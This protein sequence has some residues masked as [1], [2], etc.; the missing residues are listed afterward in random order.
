[1]PVSPCGTRIVGLLQPYV[2]KLKS[3]FEKISIFEKK[4][5]RETDQSSEKYM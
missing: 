4:C 3:E 5:K 1:M 2:F